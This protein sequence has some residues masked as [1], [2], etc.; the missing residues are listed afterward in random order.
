MATILNQIID[1]KRGEVADNKNRIPIRQLEA[2]PLFE[3]PRALFSRAIAQPGKASIIAEFKRRSP[4]KGEINP[5]VSI[6]EVVRGYERA[7]ARALSVLT[8]ANFFGGSNKDL[9]T[10]FAAVELPILR[11]DFVV[12]EYQI[13]EARAIGAA[14]VL[15]IAAALEPAEIESLAEF[16]RRLE[17]EVLL[18]IHDERELPANLDNI[19]AVGFNNR[20]L[21]DFSVDTN[22][23]LRIASKLPR[24]IIKVSESGIGDAMTIDTLK[25]AGFH[26][27][28]IGETFMKTR[29]PADACAK[30]IRQLQMPDFPA[31]YAAKG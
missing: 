26:A 2:S 1:Y 8:D 13:V 9:E 15:L 11:K 16:A 27:F 29:A 28:L 10:A 5:D 30:L 24:D 31:L 22:R 3:Q 14:A 4:S 18:E 17:L 12:D 21:H 19:S 7:G 20:N 23:S 25:L 6:V